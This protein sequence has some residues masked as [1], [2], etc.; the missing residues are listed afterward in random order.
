MV[1]SHYYKYIFIETPQTGCSAIRNELLEN[2]KGEIILNKHSVYSEFLASASKEEREYFAFSSIRNPLD[3]H[4]SS[5]LK[6]KKIIT[7]IGIRI[8]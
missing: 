3:K 7:K 2:Y 4:T 5:F 8:D 6:L 1:I